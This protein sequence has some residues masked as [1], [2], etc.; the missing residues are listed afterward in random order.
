MNI[1]RSQTEF[2]CTRADLN[3][4]GAVDF[5]ELGSDF[6]GAVG[7]AVVNDDEFPLEVAAGT[8]VSK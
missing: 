5:L 6:L 4:F 7:R 8:I 2:A 1:G 3:V